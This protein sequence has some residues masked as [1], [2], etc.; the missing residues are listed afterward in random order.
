[1]TTNSLAGRR[2][3]VTGAARGIGLA[4]A[5]LLHER[6]A[7]V[8]IGDLD[9]DVAAAAAAS[10]GPGVAGLALDV[11]DHTSYAAFL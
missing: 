7:V 10:I 1:M 3:A 9:C 5:R 6:G 4:T 2:I 8:V 11:A